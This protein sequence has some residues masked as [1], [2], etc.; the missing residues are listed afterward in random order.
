MVDL[1]K[2]LVDDIGMLLD[3]GQHVKGFGSFTVSPAQGASHLP[4]A[5]A[6]SFGLVWFVFAFVS[7]VGFCL[8]LCLFV[9]WLCCCLVPSLFCK[10]LS[11]Y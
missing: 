1:W 7:W 9:F 10:C 5:F 4:Q 2:A 11:F 3:G 6:A 8:V